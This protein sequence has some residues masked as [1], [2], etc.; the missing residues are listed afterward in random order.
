MKIRKCP[1]RHRPAAPENILGVLSNC[2]DLNRDPESKQRLIP[3]R[4][5][6]LVRCSRVSLRSFDRVESTLRDSGELWF[7]LRAN[8]G[9]PKTDL[10]TCL[11]TI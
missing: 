1:L 5:G 9:N 6:L 2:P 7:T 8:V 11:G 3:T 4:G 10:M